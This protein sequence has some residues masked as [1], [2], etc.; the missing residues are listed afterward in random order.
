M[1]TPVY[2]ISFLDIQKEFGGDTTD[3]ISLYEYQ[4]GGG[5]VPANQQPSEFSIGT[6]PTQSTSGWGTHPPMSVGMFRGLTKAFKFALEIT[7]DRFSTYNLHDELIGA[8]WDG[9]IPVDG[10]LTINSGVTVVAS[11]TASYAVDA[12]F[13]F[14]AKSKL[15]IINHGQILGHGGRGGIGG[16]MPS[17]PGGDG[18]NGGPAIAVNLVTEIQN[19]GII[20]GGGGGGGGSSGAVGCLELVQPLG[21]VLVLFNGAP[22]GGGAPFGSGGAVQTDYGMPSTQ[23]LDYYSVAGVIE[24]QHRTASNASSAALNAPG[25]GGQIVLNIP[26][27]PYILTGSGGTIGSMGAGSHNIT[28]NIN[29]TN[30]THYLAGG[31]GGL[32]GNAVD[33]ISNVKWTRFGTV[34]GRFPSGFGKI[35]NPSGVQVS[36]FL[37]SSGYSVSQ[38]VSKD[39]MPIVKNMYNGNMTPSILAQ[40][41]TPWSSQFGNYLYSYDSST[42]LTNFGPTIFTIRDDYYNSDGSQGRYAPALVTM[43]PSGSAPKLIKYSAITKNTSSV[44]AYLEGIVDDRITA[45]WVNGANV[46]FTQPNGLLNC[47]TSKVTGTFSI[48]TGPAVIDVYIADDNKGTYTQQNNTHCMFLFVKSQPYGAVIVNPQEWYATQI[49]NI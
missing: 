6:I 43:L 41:T 23:M 9:K 32:A 4:K 7:A 1:T 37:A 28:T 45:I 42:N 26:E 24:Y 34:L 49:S 14:P 13:Q 11:S 19:N 44:T 48:P 21:K 25:Q 22:G 29:F 35:V 18:E 46:P 2:N 8:G 38:I 40:N 10:T 15:T 5:N 16:I 3:G 36:N 12:S 27:S 39:L 30:T 17:T 31:K 47:S 20:A 33:G